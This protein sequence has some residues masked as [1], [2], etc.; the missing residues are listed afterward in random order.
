[1]AEK[2]T[3]QL[4]KEQMESLPRPVKEAI[5]SFDWARAV[6]DIGR[7]HDLHVDEIGEVQ[8]EVM[9]VVLGLISPK[10]FYDQMVSRVG[11][12]ENRALEVATEVNEKVFLRIRDFMKEYYAEE[13]KSQSERKVLNSAGIRLDDGEDLPEEVLPKISIEDTKNK[14]I[15]DEEEKMIAPPI[16]VAKNMNNTESKEESELKDKLNKAKDFT[17][18]PT[19]YFDP[20]REPVE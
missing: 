1:M 17:D 19:N 13:E 9:L 20:Y 7:K 14:E 8:T 5:A 2:Q 15:V 11:I 12:E 4:I 18:A 10:D 3:E 6:F 16:E